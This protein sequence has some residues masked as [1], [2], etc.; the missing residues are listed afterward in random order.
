MSWLKEGNKPAIEQELA[1]L[2]GQVKETNFLKP[3]KFSDLF[4]DK[5]T[6][7]GLIIAFILLGGQQMC[8]M[9]VMVKN[10][11]IKILKNFHLMIK[12][13]QLLNFH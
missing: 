7:K 13:M 6:I 5:G 4:K 3:A 9:F 11:L 8:G 12:S 2:Q 1:Y 10:P